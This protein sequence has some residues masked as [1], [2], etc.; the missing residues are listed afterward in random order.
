MTQFDTSKIAHLKLEPEAIADLI[1][2]QGNIRTGVRMFLNQCLIVA[3]LGIRETVR[4]AGGVHA[5]CRVAF[6]WTP[7]VTS[8]RLSVYHNL[9][10]VLSV[11]HIVEA[12]FTDTRVMYYCASWVKAKLERC[13]D[14]RQHLSLAQQAVAMFKNLDR[15][16]AKLRK[17]E[18]IG[19]FSPRAI[20]SVPIAPPANL[21]VGVAMSSLVSPLA[22]PA[23][24]APSGLTDNHVILEYERGFDRY[25][26]ITGQ[27]RTQAMERL[28]EILLEADS[29][30]IQALNEWAENGVNSGLAGLV[31]IALD[32]LEA[33]HQRQELVIA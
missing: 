20:S 11:P 24:T 12:N 30:T 25:Q 32:L 33:E 23:T 15:D 3:R 5:V 4:G 13:A 19:D 26:N 6:A 22:N 7:F 10:K 9:I 14:P 16:T 17:D 2:I 18:A 29:L 1:E 31:K 8:H 28:G 21:P 27:S